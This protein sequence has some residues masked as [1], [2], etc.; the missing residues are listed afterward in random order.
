M[1]VTI[2]FGFLYWDYIAGDSI[3]IFSDIGSD[4]LLQYYPDKVF[5]S[6][7]MQE[8]SFSQYSLQ[9]GLGKSI[10]R[11]WAKYCN[12]FDWVCFLCSEDTMNTG[13]LL[14][15]Y[16]KYL[17]IA[18]FSFFFLKKLFQN[19]NAALFGCIIW[20]F[21]SYAVIWGQHYAFL[22]NYALI[23]MTL[24][25][26]QG[27]LL[28]QK[29]S[30]IPLTMSLSLL[31]ISSYYFYWQTGIFTIL[32]VI[33]Y[34]MINK[35]KGREL[36][37][38]LFKLA[39]VAIISVCIAAFSFF[40]TF[41]DFLNSKRTYGGASNVFKLFGA[42]FRM[43]FL[44]GFFNPHIFG[45][46]S[47]EGAGGSNYYERAKLFASS[48][49]IFSLVYHFVRKKLSVFVI[50]IISLAALLVPFTSMYLTGN[51]V[52]FR[53]TYLLCILI[54]ISIAGFLRDCYEGKTDS[55]ALSKTYIIAGAAYLLL[56][57]V[58]VI[59]G[60]SRDMDINHDVLKL[61]V[62][63]TFLYFILLWLCTEKKG[64][65]P[66]GIVLLFSL[67]LVE[68]AGV[69]YP[70]INDREMVKEEALTTDLYQN[71]QTREALE[72]IKKIDTGLYRVNKTRSVFLNDALI[73][74]FNGMSFYNSVNSGYLVDFCTQNDIKLYIDNPGF[75][76]ISYEE[77]V[78]NALLSCRY[79]LNITDIKQFY[80]GGNH[81]ID[82]YSMYEKTDQG[83]VYQN[84]WC[85]PFGYLY[86]SKMNSA[87]YRAMS[88]E[89][90][91]MALT[92]AFYFSNEQEEGDFEKT[93]QVGQFSADMQANIQLLQSRGVTNVRLEGHTYTADI[94]SQTGGMLCIPIIY[95][96]NWEIQIDGR[97]ETV[98]NINGGLVGAKVGEGSH[99]VELTYNTRFF[100]MCSLLS[101]VS[102]VLFLG[103][104]IFFGLRNHK[105]M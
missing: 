27:F 91:N 9:Y 42:Q 95:D 43:E 69:N 56:M 93:I 62:V 74:G 34:S 29:Y 33:G 23:T 20:T 15:T 61:S 22:T 73:Q 82:Q 72:H 49:F 44:G 97:S 55:S 50:M 53:W 19:E 21:C 89:N 64:I 103:G 16:L 38:D 86:T 68:T 63:F 35:K 58:F 8:S 96:E 98:Y 76:R 47:F 36:L 7:T 10:D 4:T 40:P 81:G 31:L 11:V 83:T 17:A 2:L 30:M 1:A 70:C 45:M 51:P 54:C 80:I 105:K 75:V 41:N 46:K 65:K 88:K 66:Y 57:I 14:S 18:F 102:I 104:N 37:L 59:V 5:V 32:Y 101:V 77:P 90:K 100:D 39:G 24:N 87:D 60:N 84:K 79:I 48:I 99:K 3:Y 25:F 12:P 71:K 85:L 13:L 52:C 26:L 78:A 67:C 94:S 6:N 28:K 92:N